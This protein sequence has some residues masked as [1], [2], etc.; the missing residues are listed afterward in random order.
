MGSFNGVDALTG[1]YIKEGDECVLIPV[2][3]IFPDLSN[4]MISYNPT[5]REVA[6]QHIGLPFFATYNDYGGFRLSGSEKRDEKNKRAFEL[7]KISF[8]DKLL[9][10]SL[11]DLLEL[12]RQTKIWMNCDNDQDL[13]DSL[14]QLDFPTFNF[15]TTTEA[16]Y[17]S[18]LRQYEKSAFLNFW[19][20]NGQEKVL[21]DVKNAVPRQNVDSGIGSFDN[22][23]NIALTYHGDLRA[24]EAWRRAQSEPL[25]FHVDFGSY[26]LAE[27]GA[28]DVLLKD[29]AELL[30]FA[31]TR[32]QLGIALEPCRPTGGQESVM[33]IENVRCL[34]ERVQVVSDLYKK[35]ARRDDRFD[36]SI[37]KD[38]KAVKNQLNQLY[39]KMTNS[40][41]DL[42]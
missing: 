40:W 25:L 4:P 30:Q 12:H 20:K 6:Y 23:S 1:E 8:K 10:N 29:F 13:T 28:S 5:N 3:R 42:I 16:N 39:D 7:L 38:L 14:G 34:A 41:D 17:H 9:A 2:K 27:H 21:E 26:E 15:V 31:K 19:Q 18:I 22:E 37:I 11:E 35:R 24:N 32:K 36:S 33:D